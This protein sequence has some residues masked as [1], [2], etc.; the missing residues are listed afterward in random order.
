M[1]ILLNPSIQV[2]FAKQDQ[3]REKGVAMVEHKMCWT[4]KLKTLRTLKEKM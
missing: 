4:Q 3:E 2:E 1:T